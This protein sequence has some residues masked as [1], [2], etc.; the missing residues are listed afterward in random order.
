MNQPIPDEALW[1]FGIAPTA[2]AKLQRLFDATPGLACVWLYGSRARGDQ[3]RESDIDLAVEWQAGAKP[4]LLSLDIEDM[5]LIYRVDVTNLGDKLDEDF[6]RRLERDRK[7]FWDPSG[8]Y[9]AT[10]DAPAGDGAI[11]ENQEYPPSL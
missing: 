8:A 5:G 9:Q 4:G 10:R 11:S 7:V 2:Y 6:L 1:P 3:R